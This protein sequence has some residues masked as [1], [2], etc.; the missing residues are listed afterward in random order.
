MK[1]GASGAICF[2]IMLGLFLEPAGHGRSSSIGLSSRSLQALRPPTSLL[3]GVQR[4]GLLHR[5]FGACAFLHL[6]AKSPW[7]QYSRGCPEENRPGFAEVLG[8]SDPAPITLMPG[9]PYQA[10]F[11]P[12]GK[13]R[14]VE[15]LQFPA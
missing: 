13:A 8:S 10:A 7:G 15:T 11:R 12:S 2:L 4:A 5:C 14:G 6:C 3:V 9:C 1:E